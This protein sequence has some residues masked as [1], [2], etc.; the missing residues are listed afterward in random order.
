MKEADKDE[1]NFID[2]EEFKQVGVVLAFG[3]YLWINVSEV[4][5][6]VDYFGSVN[7]H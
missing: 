1:D 6:Y 7:R 2:F 5:M 3:V 4:Y